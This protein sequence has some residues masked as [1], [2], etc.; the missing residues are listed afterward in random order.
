MKNLLLAHTFILMSLNICAQNEEIKKNLYQDPNGYFS[1]IKPDGWINSEY[2]ETSRGKIKFMQ[3]DNNKINV[4]FIGQPNSFKS[5]QALMDDLKTS[6]K[7]MEGKYSASGITTKISSFKIDSVEYA[8]RDVTLTGLNLQQM[9]VEFILNNTYIT[10]GYVAPISS[11][12]AYLPKIF[13]SIS[14]ITTSK[15]TF[16]G[17][18]IQNAIIE[19]KI[20]Q[21]EINL[22]AG[23][24]DWAL[25]AIEEGLKLGPNN[26][27]LLEL[28]NKCK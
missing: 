11:F 28:K 18:N 22:Q 6:T 1:I 3:P 10:I 12:E 16:S 14:T 19:S 17:A 15:K 4:I 27:E 8:K 23:R 20:K 21:A 26:K 5:F 2:Q 25:L 9:S 7:Q 24:K 13:A